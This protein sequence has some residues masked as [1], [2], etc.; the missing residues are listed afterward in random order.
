LLKGYLRA[1]LKHFYLFHLF[2]VLYKVA[3]GNVALLGH[4]LAS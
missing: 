4:S 2:C 1:A 3:R